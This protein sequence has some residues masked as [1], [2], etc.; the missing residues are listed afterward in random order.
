MSTQKRPQ[1]AP[2]S[3]LHII[4]S[5]K[6]TQ[7][8]RNYCHQY[9][10]LFQLLHKLCLQT[11]TLDQLGVAKSHPSPCAQRDG[12]TWIS[13]RPLS[14]LHWDWTRNQLENPQPIKRCCLFWVPIETSIQ[15]HCRAQFNRWP[16]R[17]SQEKNTKRQSNKKRDIHSFFW[18]TFYFRVYTMHNIRQQQTIYTQFKT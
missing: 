11:R 2:P 4:G 9:Q 6:D 18:K 8:S 1:H 13:I 15:R 12:T 7:P 5:L 16:R 3:C 10:W 17:T 14:A